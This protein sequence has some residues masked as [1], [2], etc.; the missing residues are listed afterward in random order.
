VH[1]E[2]EGRPAFP[3]KGILTVLVKRCKEISTA[4]VARERARPIKLMTCEKLQI[5]G[6][7]QNGGIWRTGKTNLAC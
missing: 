1:S 5:I 4:S 3:E 6:F 2:F 7:A